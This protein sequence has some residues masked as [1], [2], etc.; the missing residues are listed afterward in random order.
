MSYEFQ[1]SDYKIFPWQEKHWIS[2]LERDGGLHHA[3]LLLGPSG[4]GKSRFALTLAAR[5]LCENAQ[6]ATAL[7]CGEC[8]ACHWF[9]GGNHPDFRWITLESEDEDETAEAKPAKGKKAAAKRSVQIKI[10][11]IRALDDFAGIGSHRNGNRVIVIDPA[12][13]LNAAAANSILKLL[14]E[15]PANLYFILVSSDERRLIP[16]LRSRCATWL[17]GLPERSVAE[18]WLAKQ[19]IAKAGD[20]L[21]LSGGAPLAALDAARLRELAEG[22]LGPLSR[23]GVEPLH[24]AGQWD[25]ALK[26]VPDLTPERLVATL[27]KWVHDLVRTKFSL[28]PRYLAGQAAALATVAKSANPARLLRMEKE[29]LRIKATARHPLNPQLFLEDLA[30]RYAAGVAGQAG[31]RG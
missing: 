18:A 29:L 31:G 4:T 14:E 5:L 30:C 7:P 22:V 3:L 23:A 26:S 20:V 28:P 25:A 21:G 17:F 6:G 16:T 10:D 27:Q 24:L 19:G 13:A 11:Q 8:P 12:D 1:I 9:A 2:L 15:P